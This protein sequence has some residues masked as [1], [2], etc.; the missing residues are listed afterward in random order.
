M[1]IGFQNEELSQTPRLSCWLLYDICAAAQVGVIQSI[2][3]ATNVNPQL[4]GPGAPSLVL[5]SWTQVN[6]D[7][8]A[9]GTIATLDTPMSGRIAVQEVE[10]EAEYANEVIGGSLDVND[11]Q[12]G[13][14]AVELV[15]ACEIFC[16]RGVNLTADFLPV[17]RHNVWPRTAAAGSRPFAVNVLGIQLDG[18]PI[19]CK[20]NIAGCLGDNAQQGFDSHLPLASVVKRHRSEHLE[21]ERIRESADAFIKC[22]QRL[23]VSTQRPVSAAQPE[24]SAT[25]QI[26]TQTGGYR[27][28]VMPHRRR[29]L[30]AVVEKAGDFIL[31]LSVGRLNSNKLKREAQCGIVVPRGTER[32]NA[33]SV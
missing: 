17:G 16:H 10:L 28:G 6:V 2:N 14:Q 15:S 3:V 29:L 13:L 9:I 26:I 27:S 32:A 23:L 12:H 5:A 11:G 22:R 30:A 4:T 24:V 19:P 31:Q 25:E 8:L 33:I 1:T 20:L 7:R 18:P 21:V